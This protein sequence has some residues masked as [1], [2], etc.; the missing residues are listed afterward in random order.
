MDNIE[1]AGRVEAVAKFVLELA[2]ELEMKGVID[3][4]R[5]SQRLR[6]SDRIDDQVEYI[7]VARRRLEG[8]AD[9]LDGA[10]EAR[11][12]DPAKRPGR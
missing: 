12:L 1:L 7:R 8:M 10:R 9:R 4:P 5:F 11:A 2:A 6:G 3:G